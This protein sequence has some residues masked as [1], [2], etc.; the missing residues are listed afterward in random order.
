[1]SSTVMVQQPV[2]TETYRRVRS[3]HR[4]SAA[5]FG[6]TQASM[7]VLAIIF[8]IT[9]AI[10]RCSLAFLGTGIWCGVYFIVTGCMVYVS[11]ARTSRRWIIT[12]MILSIIAAAV[13][14]LVLIPVS[15]VAV[16]ED[17]IYT[18]CYYFGLNN[19]YNERDVSIK[20]V[21]SLVGGVIE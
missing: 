17:Y 21:C 14:G 9:A 12:S 5:G 6:I 18:E 19:C 16:S 20:C 1:M 11:A 10:I 13:C 15:A 3:G 8:G 2:Q 4:K 7:G